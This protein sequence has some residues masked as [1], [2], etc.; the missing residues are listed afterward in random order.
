MR[1][2]ALL[3]RG[4]ATVRVW[5]PFVRIFHWSL[6]I[7]VGLALLTPDWG[8]LHRPI[9]Y[10]AAG[11][12]VA[13]LIWGLVGPR[14]ARFTNFVRGPR[15]V[16]AY[17]RSLR[18]GRAERHIG[19][20]PAGGA[21]IVVL[22][23][24]I[25][26]LG[27]TGWM[28]QTDYWFGI[29]WVTNLHAAIGNLLPWVVGLHLVGVVVSSWLHRENLIRAMITGEKLVEDPAAGEDRLARLR[30]LLTQ[31]TGRLRARQRSGV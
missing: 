31:V 26:G 7:L 12:V 30:L 13:R 16:L 24:M 20:N 15:T 3:A 22:L 28:S 10:G 25:I 1:A 21:M 8:W 23:S 2:P 27:V 11:L 9:G 6:V 5:D 4:T 17:L 18:E 19:H 29:D 14:H